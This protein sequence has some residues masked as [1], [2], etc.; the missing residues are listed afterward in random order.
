MLTSDSSVALDVRQPFIPP[1]VFERS[2][3]CAVDGIV[4]VHCVAPVICF[5]IASCVPGTSTSQGAAAQSQ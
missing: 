3:S 4:K 2:S 1:L 5:R